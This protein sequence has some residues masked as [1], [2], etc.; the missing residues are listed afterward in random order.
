MTPCSINTGMQRRKGATLKKETFIFTL[1]ANGQTLKKLFTKQ[2]RVTGRIATLVR[3]DLF[4]IGVGIFFPSTKCRRCMLYCR[5]FPSYFRN[6]ARSV[7]NHLRIVKGMGTDI[8]TEWGDNSDVES[9]PIYLAVK[10]TVN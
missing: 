4:Q 3:N 7:E 9:G 6:L 5:S 10:M 1:E 8:L 2:I